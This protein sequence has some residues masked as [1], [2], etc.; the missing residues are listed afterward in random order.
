MRMQTVVVLF[1]GHLLN[2]STQFGGGKKTPSGLALAA[3]Q[4]AQWEELAKNGDSE[5]EYQLGLSYSC[6]FGPGHTQTSARH[7]FCVVVL[8]GLVGVVFFFFLL[9]LLFCCVLFLVVV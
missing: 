1:I 7:W 2:G 3:L 9:L 5:A 8:F 6:G 4:R